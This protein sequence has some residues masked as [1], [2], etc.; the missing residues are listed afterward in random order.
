MKRP[1]AKLAV[2]AG[3]LGA[4]SSDGALHATR[5]E[6][7]RVRYGAEAL[8]PVFGKRAARFASAAGG[9]QEVLGEHQDAVVAMSWLEDRGMDVDDQAVTFIA[10][11]L[12]ELEAASRDRARQAWPKAW[13][14]LERRERFW[15]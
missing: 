12:A 10:G 7:K 9:L 11:R 15:T 4:D 5:I 14:R 3:A 13:K 2:S 8:V 1:W 6:T